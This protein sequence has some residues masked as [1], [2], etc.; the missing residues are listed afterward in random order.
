MNKP[1]TKKVTEKKL[2]ATLKRIIHSKIC[3]S[4]FLKFCQDLDR[5]LNTSYPKEK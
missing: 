2:I 4:D 1:T 5:D 3:D